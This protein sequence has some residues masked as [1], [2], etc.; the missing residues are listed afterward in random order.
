[1][2]R[3][4]IFQ[5]SQGL[6]EA[7]FNQVL[8]VAFTQNITKLAKQHDCIISEHQYGRAQKTCMMPVLNKLLTVQL[9]IQKRTVGIVFD[10]DAKGF[11]ARI[12]SGHALAA[13]RIIGYSKNSVNISGRLWA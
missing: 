12:I 10:N 8:Q 1:M 7:D 4:K 3:W 9:L 13:L 2:L 11:Y 6:L 5:G